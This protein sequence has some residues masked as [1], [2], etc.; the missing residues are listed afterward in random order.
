MEPFSDPATVG[1]GCGEGADPPVYIDGRGDAVF[2]VSEAGMADGASVLETGAATYG[3]GLGE[4]YRT[5]GL[6]STT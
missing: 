5:A 3:G 2:E 4:V 1:Y 6:F